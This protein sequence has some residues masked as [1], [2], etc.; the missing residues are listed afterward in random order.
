MKEWIITIVLFFNYFALSYF[1]IINCIYIIITILSFS[2]IRKYMKAQIVVQHKQL[3]RTSFYMPISVISPAYNEEPTIIQSVKSLL[4]LHYPEFEIVI[5]ND[6]SKDGTLNVLIKHYRLIKINKEPS[7]NLP[8]EP[9]MSVYYSQD[10]PNLTVI[11]KKNGGKADALNSGINFAKYPLVAPIDADSL[12]ESKVLLNMVRPFIE[13]RRT[14]AVGGII[15]VVNG[16]K[17][18]SG[19]VV[20]INLPSSFL[21]RF[22]VVEYLRAFLFGRVGWD[23]IHSLLVISG[24]FGIFKKK[25]VVECGGYRHDTIGE[26]MELVVRMHR[27]YIEKKI[28]Y[29][30]TFLPEPVCWTEVPESTKVLSKQR[31]RWQK[32][33]MDSMLFHKKML[34]NPKYKSIGLIAMPFFFFFE[35]LSPVIELSG[36]I[37]FVFSWIF[38]I[39]NFSFAILFLSASIVLGIVLSVGSLAL[40]ELSFRR[41]PKYSHIFNLFIFSV[42]ENFGY[43]QLHTLWRL[44]GMIEYVRGEKKW[45]EMVRKGFSSSETQ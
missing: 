40:E 35:M 1:L 16:C 41:Y 3:F 4:Q 13:D 44:Q 30:I 17:V 42:L 18:Q 8:C 5:V 14:I 23:A 31:I 6:G 28:P 43:R 7:S 36:Y 45:G 26:D 32:G 27:I 25:A 34:F 9:I 22:Q 38:G 37:I 33:L 20:D 24:A 12:L 39:I 11:D 10:Y 21:A 19:E 2:A 15:R 29:R